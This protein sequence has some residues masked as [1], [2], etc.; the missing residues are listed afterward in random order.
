MLNLKFQT[1]AQIK[2]ELTQGCDCVALILTNGSTNLIEDSVQFKWVEYDKENNE[3]GTITIFSENENNGEDFEI[4]DR[5]DSNDTYEV[6]E[7]FFNGMSHNDISFI[8]TS[9][10]YNDAIDFSLKNIEEV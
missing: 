9:K 8:M 2:N 4:G 10:H 1:P 3:T 7:W 5:I 6:L